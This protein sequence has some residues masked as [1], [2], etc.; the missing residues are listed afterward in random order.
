[1][2]GKLGR[3]PRLCGAHLWNHG[4]LKEWVNSNPQFISQSRPLPYMLT[5]ITFSKSSKYT[6]WWTHRAFRTLPSLPLAL[7]T[8]YRPQSSFPLPRSIQSSYHNE[9]FTAE[10][11]FTN[12]LLKPQANTYETASPHGPHAMLTDP[13]PGLSITSP[14]T[15]KN[16]IRSAK[17]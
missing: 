8:T 4:D 11:T 16:L 10:N 2:E 17:I 12:P 15:K 13:I 1:M 3:S 9:I 6:I 7:T 5:V 14:V